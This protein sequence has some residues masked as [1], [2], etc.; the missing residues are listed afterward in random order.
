MPD[1]W[2]ESTRSLHR[3]KDT[4]SPCLLTSPAQ[5]NQKPPGRGWLPR[6]FK[7]LP[8]V[9]SDTPPIPDAPPQG[10]ASDQP[11]PCHLDSHQPQ[12]AS[13][14]STRPRPERHVKQ[15]CCP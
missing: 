13:S 14:L 9:L 12:V 4:S 11:C 3:P 6:V 10:A 1:V 7:Q 15:C 2:P 5:Q 8:H